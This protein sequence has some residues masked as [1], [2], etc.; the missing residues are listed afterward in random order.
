MESHKINKA[1][2]TLKDKQQSHYGRKHSAEVLIV[3]DFSG[4]VS[5]S[6]TTNQYLFMSHGEKI[7]YNYSSQ[8]YNHCKYPSRSYLRLTFSFHDLLTLY[9]GQIVDCDSSNVTE[10]FSYIPFG[11]CNCSSPC[12]NCSHLPPCYLFITVQ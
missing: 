1:K 5:I 10:M 8:C 7:I 6:N 11:K 9:D 4:F 12:G 3:P 2:M